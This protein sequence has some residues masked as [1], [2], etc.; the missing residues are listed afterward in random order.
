MAPEAPGRRHE[1]SRGRVEAGVGELVLRLIATHG[2]RHH[3]ERLGEQEGAA[4]GEVG[5]RRTHPRPVDR[6]EGPG[7]VLA[8][9]DGGRQPHERNR[10]RVEQ[11]E[12]GEPESDR[13]DHA[14]ARRDAGDEPV[15]LV[16]GQR[17][18]RPQADEPAGRG[19]DQ[20]EREEPEVDHRVLRIPR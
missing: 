3:G 15:R 14:E 18:E 16:G 13:R 17:P 5:P 8:A 6:P 10:Q 2:R 7:Q 19:G 4:H 11:V 20:D 1:P 9:E 12:L